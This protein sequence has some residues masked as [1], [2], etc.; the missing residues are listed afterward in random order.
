MPYRGPLS[1]VAH[2]LVGGLHQSMFYVGARTVPELQERGQFVRITAGRAQ[3]E[4]PA[5]HPD[6]RRG[7][8]L[9]RAL[10]PAR[11]RTDR[12]E[13]PVRR[14]QRLRTTG[15]SRTVGSAAGPGGSPGPPGRGTVPHAAHRPVAVHPARRSRR[16]RRAAAVPAGGELLRRPTGPARR[17]PATGRAARSV[18]TYCRVPAVLG[19]RS[20]R[21]ASTSAASRSVSTAL[22]MSRCACEVGEPAHPEE[23]VAQ[24]QQRPA[25]TRPPRGRGPASSPAGRSRRRVPCV[26]P[27]AFGLVN[28][29]NLVASL[30]CRRSPRLAATPAASSPSPRSAPCYPGRV[31]RPARHAEQ[32]R[33]RRSAPARRAAPG[34]SAR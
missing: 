22:E 29:P 16:A 7:A 17:S 1:A 32:H 28:E 15:S 8:E 23:A 26:H 19:A 12:L 4:P 30:P 20:S 14:A 3:G 25:L 31:H 34:S 18:T 13:Q 27:S 9:L 24:D 5:R 10:T 2:Q 6:D 11:Q 21:P 33:G